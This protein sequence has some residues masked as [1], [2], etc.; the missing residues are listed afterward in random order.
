MTHEGSGITQKLATIWPQGIVLFNYI[1][2]TF[3]EDT[4][5][6]NFLNCA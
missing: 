2:L 4:V 5:A 1:N 6:L 3:P